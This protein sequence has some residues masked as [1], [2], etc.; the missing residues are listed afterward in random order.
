VSQNPPNTPLL[1]IRD[2]SV[3]FNAGKAGEHCVLEKV[4]LDIAPGEVVGL[5]GGSG[6]G[7]TLLSLACIGLLPGAATCTGSILWQGQPVT[8]LPAKDWLG[9]RGH[10]IAMIFQDAQASLNP[11]YRI[12]DQ[13]RWVLQL[14]RGL[15][16]EAADHEAVQMIRSVQLDDP[17]RVLSSYPHELSGGMCQRVMIALALV[18][19]PELLI[20]DEPTSALD[21]LVQAE[22]IELLVSIHRQ[23]GL[24]M[25]LITH[26][27]SMASRLAEKIAVIKDGQIVEEGP[28]CIIFSRA[29][30]PYTKSLLSAAGLLNAAV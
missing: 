24:A 18:C 14:H 26:D 5:V 27:L 1:S 12:R 8:N 23:M 11:V 13:F 2:L 15:T 10:Q 30:H 20:A 28:A 16:G 6:S 9:I 19:K 21:R 17:A 25:L 29:N 7:K 4:S 3:A 22:I